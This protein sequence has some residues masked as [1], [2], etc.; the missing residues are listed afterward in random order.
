MTFNYQRYG[1][2]VGSDRAVNAKTGRFDVNASYLHGDG[3]YAFDTFTFTTANAVGRAGPTLAQ[4][5]S[6]YD[7]ATYPWLLN[8]SYFNVVTQGYQEW[9]VPSTGTYRITAEGASGVGNATPQPQGALIQGDFDL[10]Q[11]D[12]IKIV[13]GQPG[14]DDSI[15]DASGGGGSYVVASPY[16]TNASIL[17]IAGGG[18][19]RNDDTGYTYSVTSAQGQAGTSGGTA[20]GGGGSGGGINGL[21]GDH[22]NQTTM[23]GAGFFGNAVLSVSGSAKIMALSF[24]NGST[25]GQANYTTN[26]Y[27]RGGFGGGGASGRNANFGPAGGGGGY[28]GGSAGYNSRNGGGGGSYNNGANQINTAGGANSNARGGHGQVVITKI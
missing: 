22:G 12:I 27:G 25:G 13:V 10:T 15:S 7:T 21:G 6:S 17:V 11:E 19:G 14:L 24:V 18:G 23:G 4:F 26:V 9:T 28:S 3:L 8:T 16:N 20:P 5:L 1:S 2:Y